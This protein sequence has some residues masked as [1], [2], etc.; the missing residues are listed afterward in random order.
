MAILR[1][2]SE[3]KGFFVACLVCALLFPL[4]FYAA[5]EGRGREVVALAVAFPLIALAAIQIRAAI[6]LAIVYVVL[7]G[8]LRR[9]LI[10]LVGWS[11]MDPLLL[12]GTGLAVAISGYALTQGE[13]TLDTPL[14]RWAAALMA[15]MALQMFNPKQGG[16]AVGVAGVIFLMAPLFWFWVGR[17]YASQEFMRLLLF[18]V[19]TPL[20]IAAMLFG[21]VQVF[22]GYLPYQMLWY[23]TA[24]Y[25]GLGNVETGLAP[26][27]FFASGTEHGCFLIT[28]GIVLW[29]AFL[30]RNKATILLVLPILFG[31]LL[32]G[33]R[34]PVVKLLGMA[35]VLWALMGR[36]SAAWV[37][38]FLFALLVCAVGFAWSISSVSTLNLDPAA[39]SKLQRQ[40]QLL[41]ESG[42]SSTVN[43]HGTLILN[44]YISAAQHP[45][46]LGLG[47]TSQAAAKFGGSGHGTETDFGDVMV[48]TGLVGG[49]I[50]H[51][52]IVLI[53][54]IAVRYWARTRSLLALSLVGIL[55][56][57]FTLWLGGGLYAV[58][59]I[60]W[61]CIGALDKLNRDWE[62]G[63]Q[64]GVST[65]P[66]SHYA[67]V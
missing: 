23:N 46:G 59:A 39:Q 37:P 3:S 16:L 10:P 30:L 61:L 42:E 60:V 58:S 65:V 54:F 36:N 29:A 25:L 31:V 50:Y 44:G 20:G 55:G 21:F 64:Q 52:M 17:T 6:V 63:Q 11:G 57:N 53:A 12:L 38:R 4:L 19:L 1:W 13:L 40:T 56:V 32:T 24:G 33:S 2:Y 45:L 15:L 35:V 7:L 8:D 27:S 34:G 47:A 41:E 48:A 49:L 9:L 62:R 18:R 51:V 28:V 14:A 67:H 22:Y 26:I 43:I 66:S 5:S